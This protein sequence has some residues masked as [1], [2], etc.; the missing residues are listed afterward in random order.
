MSDSKLRHFERED[1]GRWLLERLRAGDPY[2]FGS[3]ETA[4]PRMHEACEA[5]RRAGQS[6]VLLLAEPDSGARQLAQASNQILFG[7]R[8]PFVHEN[9][10]A[11]SETLLEVELVGGVRGGRHGGELPPGLISQAEGGTLY[12]DDA[13]HLSPSNQSLL[14]RLIEE[15]LYGPVDSGWG[16]VADVFLEAL[17]MRVVLCADSAESFS[18][19]LREALTPIRVPPLRERGVDL[20]LLVRQAAKR[21]L[22]ASAEVW[23]DLRSHDWP[24]NFRGFLGVVSALGEGALTRARVEELLARDDWPPVPLE[25]Y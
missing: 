1:R 7:P 22:R 2:R 11:V 9:C 21:P 6:A 19:A 13:D 3:V 23:E 4:C 20:E 25:F 14:V 17:P 12:L 16:T 10:E 18:P 5:L 8:A 24:T 15:G